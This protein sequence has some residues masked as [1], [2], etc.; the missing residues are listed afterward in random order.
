MR[1][2]LVVS[3]FNR[4]LTKKMED[5]AIEFA[6]KKNIKII[7]K[8]LVPGAYDMPLV[9]QKL[10]EIK[11]IDAV[12]CLG[13]I[14]KGQTEHDRVIAQALA[15]TL[16]ELSLNTKKPILFGIIGPGASY[17][18]AKKRVQEYAIR[19]MEAAI[20]MKNTIEKI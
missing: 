15:K 11:E 3:E 14:V 17:E 12:V 16:Q 18:K 8:V 7:K 1:I 20:K 6:Q 2:G 19:A 5:E 13:A 9:V 10:A 4:E